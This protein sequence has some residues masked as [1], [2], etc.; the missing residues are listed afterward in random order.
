MH[1]YCDY[2][3]LRGF[4]LVPSWGATIEQAWLQY[5]PKGF[6]QELLAAKLFHA[7]TIRLWID[8]DAWMIDPEQIST[9]F[10][11]AVTAIGQAGMKVMP[12]LANRWHDR[13]YDYG[14]TYLEQLSGDFAPRA[15]YLRELTGPYREDE[16]I[17]LWDLCN[18]PAATDP[19][20]EVAALELTWLGHCANVLRENGVRQPLT[21]GTHMAGDNIEIFADL[22]DVLCCHPYG[23][24]PPEL[25]QML[26][27]TAAIA[28]NHGKPMLI[29]EAIPGALDDLRR[30]ECARWNIELMEDFGFGWM[31]WALTEGRAI[32][33]RLDRYDSNGLDDQG[34]HIWVRADGTPRDGLQFLTIPPRFAPPWQNIQ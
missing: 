28:R 32:S 19:A 20:S 9:A 17:L 11:D 33:T 1:R 12:C 21:V 29:N 15:Q 16:R 6:R 22:C 2:R 13:Q 7:N 14:G 18:E 26:E 34:F 31:G 23:R 8:F 3:W 25:T 30:A 4:N 27:R 24:T 5:D 10:A